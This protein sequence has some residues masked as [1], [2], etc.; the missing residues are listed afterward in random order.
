[1]TVN[2]RITADDSWVLCGKQ[3]WRSTELFLAKGLAVI[4]ACMDRIRDLARGGLGAVPPSEFGDL[5]AA[6]R[7]RMLDTGDARYAVLAEMFQGLADWWSPVGAVPS[8]LAEAIVSRLRDQLRG[9]L[10]PDSPADGH[11][12]AVDLLTQV[13]A[14]ELP[15][16]E[17]FQQGY[18]TRFV[19]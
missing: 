5:A 6:C 18:V 19:A 2:S 8:S 9:V 15:E 1:M 17:W 3:G 11:A 16:R 14:C 13:E 7:T 10:D 12:R 4:L